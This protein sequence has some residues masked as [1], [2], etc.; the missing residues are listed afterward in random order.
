MSEIIATADDGFSVREK[1]T[2]TIIGKMIKFL[3]GRYIVDKTETLPA[4]TTLVALGVVTVW[5]NWVDGKPI[6]H[7]VTQPGQQHPERDELPDQDVSLWPPGLNDEPSDP[8]RDSRYLHLVDPQTGADYTFITDSYGGRRGVG[9]LKSQIANVRSVHPA[10]V[11]LVK[12]GSVPWKT[13]YGMKQ[14][15]EFKV[16]GWRGKQD[17]GAPLQQPVERKP[18]ERRALPAAEPINDSIPF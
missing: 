10:A 6:D 13:R 9:E 18:T 17:S 12:L 7:R 5:V 14:R 16:V 2:G 11:P 1:T 3:D 15:P 8:W 4:D